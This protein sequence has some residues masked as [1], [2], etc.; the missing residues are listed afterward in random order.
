[1]LCGRRA[2][3]RVQSRLPVGCEYLQA[4]ISVEAEVDALVGQILQRHGRLDG[5][6][7]AAG[8]LQ[9]SLISNKTEEM[10]RAVLAPKVT[11]SEVLLR[12]ALKI[13]V[14]FFVSFSTVSAAFGNAGQ[15]DYAA[16]CAFQDALTQQYAM[17]T[18]RNTRILSIDWPLW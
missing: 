16:A 10:F 13:D 11:G 17:Q 2:T 1:M 4:D 12:A 5:V 15:V 6:L 7:H 3:E 9:D 8:L 18:P 14:A